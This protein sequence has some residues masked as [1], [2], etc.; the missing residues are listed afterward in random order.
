MARFE[1]NEKY[2]LKCCGHFDVA[3]KMT[4]KNSKT[5]VTSPMFVGKGSPKQVSFFFFTA[6]SSVL[7]VNSLPSIFLNH[8]SCFIKVSSYF[9]GKGGS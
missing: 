1:D 6:M 5:G 3:L 7:L 2:I 8:I 9:A 4:L